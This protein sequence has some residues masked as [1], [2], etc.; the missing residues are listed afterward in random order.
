MKFAANL[1]ILIGFCVGTL[2]AAG[3]HSPYNSST[4]GLG[5]GEMGTVTIPADQ[6]ILDNE[7]YATLLFLLGLGMLIAG[8]F[9]T[10]AAKGSAGLVEGDHHAQGNALLGHLTGIEAS[11]RELHGKAS[12]MNSSELH[13]AITDVSEGPIYDLTSE[14]EHWT[15]VLGFDRYSQVWTGVASGERL[16]QRAWSMETDGHS[17]EAIAELDYAARAFA[18]AKGALNS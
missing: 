10:K 9:L 12:S 1:L 5:P 18:E 3:F 15:Q 4:H 13:Q 8:G 14:F 17:E 16:V 2:G 7:E 11:L 6:G